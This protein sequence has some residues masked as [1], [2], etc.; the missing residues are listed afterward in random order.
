MKLSIGLFAAVNAVADDFE[1]PKICSDLN[2]NYVN[3]WKPYGHFG[4]IAGSFNGTDYETFG[5]QN[6]GGECGF[7]Y[8]DSSFSMVNQTCTGFQ[9]IEGAELVVD[10]AVFVPKG[11][12]NGQQYDVVGFDITGE[13]NI[14]QK[15]DVTF[16]FTNDFNNLLSNFTIA[17]DYANDY[18]LTA[19]EFSY[20]RTF[21]CW[22]E[23]APDNRL[24]AKLSDEP[25][26]MSI[27]SPIIE[28][29]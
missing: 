21:D 29:N 1:R 5:Q 4:N 13:V 24:A 10:N 20:D 18:N 26:K 12:Y 15:W 25:K 16:D 19:P 11:S 22:P 2:A 28:T 7:Q 23:L 6:E 3:C 9:P 27:F 8:R 17:L 14:V